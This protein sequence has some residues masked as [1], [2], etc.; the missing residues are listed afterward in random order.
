M[1]VEVD[2]E[3]AEEDEAADVAMVGESFERRCRFE[4]VGDG[5]CTTEDDDESVSDDTGS[6]GEDW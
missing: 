1:E 2:D 3:E 4:T 5:G 6:S